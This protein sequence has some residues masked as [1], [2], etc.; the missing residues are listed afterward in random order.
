[1]CEII[2]AV[3]FAVLELKSYLKIFQKIHSNAEKTLLKHLFQK[4]IYKFLAL[5]KIPIS[6][7]VSK[8]HWRKLVQNLIDLLV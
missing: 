7:M 5:N 4:N 2:S 3:F 8:R 6:L 1:M